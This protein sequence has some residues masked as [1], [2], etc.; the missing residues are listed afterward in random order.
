VLPTRLIGRPGFA[1]DT[2]LKLIVRAGPHI[3]K[4]LPADGSTEQACLASSVLPEWLRLSAPPCTEKLAPRIFRKHTPGS[5]NYL[6]CC[7]EAMQGN[8]EGE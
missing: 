2:N 7:G 5:A 4:G 8:L 1:Q 3:R 6:R